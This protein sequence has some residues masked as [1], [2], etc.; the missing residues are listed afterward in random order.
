MVFGEV[1][2]SGW[3]AWCLRRGV[4]SIVMLGF[5]TGRTLEL[6]VDVGGVRRGE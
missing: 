4:E 5:V 1:M 3:E 6:D 2:E